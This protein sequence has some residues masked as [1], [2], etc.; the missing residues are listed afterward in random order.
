MKLGLRQGAG[1]GKP[2]PL[3]SELGLVLLSLFIHCL[4]LLV[5]RITEY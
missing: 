3:Y 2:L 1:E 4:V 5:L